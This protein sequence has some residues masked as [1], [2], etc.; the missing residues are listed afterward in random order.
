MRENSRTIHVDVPPVRGSPYSI[1]WLGI[2]SVAE[3]VLQIGKSVWVKDGEE[4]IF[5]LAGR[6]LFAIGYVRVGPRLWHDA[7]AFTVSSDSGY[8][9]AVALG[10]IQQRCR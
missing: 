5:T 9:V 10:M 6:H 2:T 7:V 4:G 1:F 8:V 3:H